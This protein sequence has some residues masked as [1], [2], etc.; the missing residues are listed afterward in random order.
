METEAGRGMSLGEGME[1][2][3]GSGQGQGTGMGMGEGV[4]EREAES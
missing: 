3:W 4:G 1:K 2:R